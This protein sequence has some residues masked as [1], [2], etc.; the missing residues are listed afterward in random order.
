MRHCP[1][2]VVTWTKLIAGFMAVF[3][4]LNKAGSL[5]AEDRPRP[6]EISAE[7]ADFFERKIRPVLSD[8]CLECHSAER[9]K[10]KGGLALD[11]ADGLRKGS[12]SG[13]V[14]VPGNPD[15]SRL[16]QAIRYKDETLQMPP[17]ERL[18]PAQISD[19]E[20]WVRMGAP[21]PRPEFS[22]SNSQFSILHSRTNHWAFHALKV[23]P[24]PKVKDKKWPRD[25]IDSF[26]LS[27]L[28]DRRLA[29]APAADKVTLIRR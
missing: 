16:I 2:F 9:G 25:P 13:A 23:E 21:D 19:F 6:R 22:I 17:K 4:F 18:T 15:K 29:P 27:E 12:D 14:I 11:S 10:T 3:V 28:E 26:I 20:A 7:Q 24:L 5:A 1:N 8:R